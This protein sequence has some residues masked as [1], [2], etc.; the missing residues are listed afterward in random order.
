M[1]AS[2]FRDAVARVH[3]AGRERGHYFLRASDER[4]VGRSLTINERALLSFGSCSYLGLEFDPRLIRAGAEAFERFGS[5]TSYSRGYLSNPLYERLE[6]DLLP[7]IFGVD[8]VLVAPST[9]VAHHIVLPALITE[10]TA[11]VTDHQVHR[12]VDDA[13]TLQC[14]RSG[15]K[16]HV[17]RHG[18]LDEAAELIERLSRTHEEVWFCCDGVYSMYGDYLPS[19][20]LRS[21]LDLAPN[22]R[23][24]VDDAHGMSWAGRHGRGH[25][26]SRFALDERVVMVTSFA[27]AF[28]SGGSA[29]VAKDR[30]VIDN[31]RLV[32][33]PYAF[34]GPLRPG[35][36]GVAIASAELH[37]SDELP[38]LQRTLAARVALANECCR[39]LEIPTVIENEAPIRF[40]ALGRAEAVYSVADALADDGFHVNVSGFPAVPANLGGLRI[41]INANHTEAQVRALF[42]RIAAHLP[43]VLDRVGVTRDE[44][45]SQ[46]EQV[47]P[48]FLRAESARRVTERTRSLA[49]DTKVTF[50]VRTHQS[51]ANVDASRWNSVFDRSGYI[52]TASL[53]AA[54][55]AFGPDAIRPENR[56]KFFYTTVSDGQGLAA[57]AP[58]SLSLLKDDAFMSEEVSDALELA[59]RDDPLLF[60][61][62]ALVMGTLA[63]EGEHLYL[64]PGPERSAALVALVE[65]ATRIAREQ[66]LSTVVLR[67]L[68]ADA[69]VERVLIGQGFVPAPLLPA[70]ELSLPEGAIESFVASASS[71]SKRQFLR[72][73]LRNQE[74]FDVRCFDA[75]HA[76]DE[77]TLARMH[78][79]Y[80]SVA[81]RNRRINLFPLPIEL[82]REH[83]R[84]RGWTLL[85]LYDRAR[86]GHLAAWGALRCVDRDVRALYCGVDYQG[87]EHDDVSPYRQLLF[88]VVAQALSVGAT[89]VSLGMGAEQEKRR[90]GAIE[91][92]TFA[93]V[94]AEDEFRARQL[95]EFVETIAAKH[96]RKPS[97]VS[98]AQAR[99]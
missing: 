75:E 35:D 39:E 14:A 17:V 28:A 40:I 58:F 65:E 98:G 73:R 71:K 33:G 30:K 46:F 11:V 5:Q 42:E 51:I 68:R 64:R 4:F 92:P 78:A 12:S 84:T 34:S 48:P 3:S 53:A 26:L 36:L 93:F 31:A 38:A 50:D 8:E 9:S 29:V 25:F 87:F 95:Q 80:L 13:L 32:G 82:L 74:R 69:E 19:S 43:A 90:L 24:Y 70:F 66:A 55:R 16:K 88:S 77:P 27:K 59:R 49:E 89:K 7:R 60:T 83:A 52:D 2:G 15:A 20:F 22:V 6:L 85:A 21:L 62:P 81:A 97:D 54:E 76:P 10:K 23:L 72:D 47:L 37:L 96:T 41:A 63:S 56:W 1:D 91:A 44:V 57:A 45:R 86:P 94:R 99:P 61:A 79:M 67:D 18:R